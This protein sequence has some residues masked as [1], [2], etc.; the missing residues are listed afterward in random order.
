M[1]LLV[2]VVLVLS[3]YLAR[4]LLRIS[5]LTIRVLIEVMF[6]REAQSLRIEVDVILSEL[7]L[8]LMEQSR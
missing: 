5:S 1:T 6:F 4:F 8:P 2:R 7:L 3:S